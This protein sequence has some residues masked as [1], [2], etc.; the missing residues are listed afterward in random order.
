M[1]THKQQ[2]LSVNY[3]L[4]GKKKYYFLWN[5]KNPKVTIY[6]SD[7]ASMWTCCGL[8]IKTK[9]LLYSTNNWREGGREYEG[10]SLRVE[11]EV[12]LVWLLRIDKCVYL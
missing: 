4:E 5:T 2:Q 3:H 9:A 1:K 11:C 12:I 7:K 6:S 8:L 10:S